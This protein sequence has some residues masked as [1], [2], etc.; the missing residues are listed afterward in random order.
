[1]V[2]LV[3]NPHESLSRGRGGAPFVAYSTDDFVQACSRRHALTLQEL[4]DELEPA[5][6]AGVRRVQ[7]AVT[8]VV[9]GEVDEAQRGIHP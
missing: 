2:S 4:A 6:Q 1:M 7:A 9:T 5:V 3:K 8:A